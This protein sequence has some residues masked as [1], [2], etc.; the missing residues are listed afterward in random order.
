[1]KAAQEILGLT[2]RTR[3]DF[4]FLGIGLNASWLTFIFASYDAEP[5]NAA[6]KFQVDEIVEHALLVAIDT[7]DVD[8]VSVIPS[9]FSLWS[10]VGGRLV[11][12]NT[13]RKASFAPR[14]SKVGPKE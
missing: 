14:S 4:S 13:I 10:S 6:S 1:M 3:L 12:R 8:F 11:Q 9:H 7:I 2:F 5:I